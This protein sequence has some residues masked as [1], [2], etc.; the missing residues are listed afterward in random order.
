MELWNH[1]TTVGL[2]SGLIPIATLCQATSP[3]APFL[4]VSPVKATSPGRVS[5]FSTLYSPEPSPPTDLFRATPKPSLPSKAE[6]SEKKM[7]FY[8]NLST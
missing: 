3:P 1:G 4:L 2:G 7:G 5:L 8:P 6:P